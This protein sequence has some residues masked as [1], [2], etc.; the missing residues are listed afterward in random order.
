MET[1]QTA[2]RVVELIALTG[3]RRGEACDLKWSE[4]NFADRCL[5]LRGTKTGRSTRPLGRPALELLQKLPKQDDEWVFPNSAGTGGADLKK[6]IAKV[7]DAADLSDARSHVLRRTFA[8]IAAT[9][10]YSDATIGEL[11]GHSRR[12]VTARHY[13]RLPDAALVAASDRTSMQIANALAGA[14][15][16]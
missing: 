3:L 12:S 6:A 15:S 14:L 1:S 9:E 5:R 2:T 13:I 10:G 4:I 7:F 16:R 8:S 11:L